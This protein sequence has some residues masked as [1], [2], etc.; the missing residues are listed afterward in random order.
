VKFGQVVA[1][2]MPDS[3][4]VPLGEK[5]FKVKSVRATAPDNLARSWVIRVRAGARN[6][7]PSRPDLIS[8]YIQ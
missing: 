2:F 5:T 6:P 8:E 7:C 4:Y 3:A 1:F